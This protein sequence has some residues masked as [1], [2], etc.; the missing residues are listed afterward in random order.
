[1]AEEQGWDSERLRGERRMAKARKLRTWSLGLLGGALVLQ[2]VET[3]V[4]LVG[5]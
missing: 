2:A 5:A 3:V 4:D 1:M